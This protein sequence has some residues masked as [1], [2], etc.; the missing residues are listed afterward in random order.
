M[1]QSKVCL[2][3]LKRVPP[4]VNSFQTLHLNILWETQVYPTR[5][6]I[7]SKRL[8]LM[9][10]IVTRTMEVSLPRIS[11]CS[12][13]SLNLQSTD[14]IL[15]QRLSLCNKQPQ[16]QISLSVLSPRS[17]TQ[18]SMHLKA[19]KEWLVKS[20]E[21]LTLGLLCTTKTNSNNFNNLKRR[22]MRSSNSKLRGLKR[23]AKVEYNIG[24]K[25]KINHTFTIL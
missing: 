15:L 24:F 12:V 6:L 17:K 11:K 10:C 3:H 1:L 22:K 13:K 25:D 19:S 4:Q 7:S 18:I 9:A 8:H 21:V 20:R 16:M 2:C 23:A 14:I 5:T